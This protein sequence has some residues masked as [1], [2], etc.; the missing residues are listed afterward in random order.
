MAKNN[1]NGNRGTYPARFERYIK[2]VKGVA[3]V[4]DVKAPVFF[5][6]SMRQFYDVGLK[7]S[8]PGGPV[9]GLTLSLADRNGV[10]QFPVSVEKGQFQTAKQGIEECIEDC[11]S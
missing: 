1:G 5:H 3:H 7:Y 10:Y 11:L 9:I 6:Y 4:R 8:G 2:A